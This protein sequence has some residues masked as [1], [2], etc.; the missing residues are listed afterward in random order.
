MI[1]L[2]GGLDLLA[3]RGLLAGHRQDEADLDRVWANAPPAANAPSANAV[4]ARKVLR[5]IGFL[6]GGF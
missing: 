2:D 5:N 6:L 1:E 4:P 3:G